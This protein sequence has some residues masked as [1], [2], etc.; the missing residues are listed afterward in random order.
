MLS[1]SRV[2]AWAHKIPTSEEDRLR[3]LALTLAV[4]IVVLDIMEVVVVVEEAIIT[5][6]E[7]DWDTP[8]TTSRG[9]MEDTSG[10]H[11][12]N[13]NT[14]IITTPSTTGLQ[15][16]IFPEVVWPNLI[17][18]CHSYQASVESWGPELTTI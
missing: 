9:H 8:G 17:L 14:S 16:E 11:I 1:G 15:G 2:L 4:D 18:I 10:L 6:K 12:I 3:L 13:T 5:H 7:M